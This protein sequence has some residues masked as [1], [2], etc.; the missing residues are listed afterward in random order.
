MNIGLTY[1]GSDKKHQFYKQWLQG[2]EEDIRVIRLSETADDENEIDN[3][4]AL[5]LSGGIDINPKLYGG[6]RDYPNKPQKWH[7]LRD[8]FESHVFRAALNHQIPMLGIC[9]GLQ[10][11]NVFFNGTLVQDLG[12]ESGNKIHEGSPDKQ[13]LV[14][15]EQDSL[16]HRVTGVLSGTVNS[17]HHQAIDKLGKGLKINS[18]APD[19]TIE[20]IEWL[21]RE[22][23]PFFLG[24]QWHAERMFLFD[25][26]NDPLSA[27]IR[28]HF[29][30]E[31]RR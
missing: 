11:I 19:G 20:G 6:D 24:I 7:D 10:L 25:L 30:N 12:A 18:K 8:S 5:V 21:D 1:T 14:E 22:K 3:C 26:Q 29:I 27:S 15:I 9:R 23:K 28:N 2:E 4:D 17:A 16:L 31:I 13:H